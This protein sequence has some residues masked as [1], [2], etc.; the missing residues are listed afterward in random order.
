MQ[1]LFDNSNC[2]AYINIVVYRDEYHMYCP[3]NTYLTAIHYDKYFN[4]YLK[5]YNM[6]VAFSYLHLC[7]IE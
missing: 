7:L 3:I 1:T 4:F 6:C 5:W 2:Y